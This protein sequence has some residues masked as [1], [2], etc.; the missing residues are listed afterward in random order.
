[1]DELRALA[2][3]DETT[4]EYGSPSYITQVRNRS[5]KHTYVVT[6]GRAVRLGLG[7]QAIEPERARELVKAVIGY[8]ETQEVIRVDRNM[9]EG[10]GAIPCTLYITAGFAQIAL[11]WHKSLFPRTPGDPRMTSV[12]VPQWPERLIMVDPEE[13][14]TL[15]LGTDYFG[16]AKKSFLRMAMYLVKKEGRLGVH[17]GGKVLRV[18]KPGGLD[19]VGMLLFGL[20]GTGKTTLTVHDHSLKEPEGVI[21]RQDDVMVMDLGGSAT[22]TEDSFYIKTEGLEPSQRVLYDA[23]RHPEAVLENV[24]V[25]PEGK[26]DFLDYSLTTNGRAI[27]PRDAVEG[28]DSRINLDRVDKVI[29]ITRRQDVVGP[30]ARLSHEQAAAFFMLGESIETSAGDPSRAGQSKREVGTNPFIIGPEGR[31]GNRFLEILRANPA[32]ECFLMNTGSVGPAKIPVAASSAIIREIARG[33]VTWGEDP[34]WGYWSPREVPGLDLAPYDPARYLSPGEY[35][36][37]V[38][39]LKEERIAW[40]GAFE[41][42]DPSIIRALGL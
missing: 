9:G 6:N 3:K 37:R 21:I 33:T 23:A 35:R 28:A 16:E 40:L 15:I 17:A 42:L 41:D 24:A 26:I 29:F 8:L 2:S 32:T 31:E 11:M 30:V 25:G 19:P 20:S 38:K 13:A 1:V 34:V 14:V 27:V 36:E 4:T 10:P 5:A 7:Q 18:S 39:R 12:Y 22:G